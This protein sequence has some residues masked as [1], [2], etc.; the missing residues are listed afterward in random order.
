MFTILSLIKLSNCLYWAT[1]TEVLRFPRSPHVRIVCGEYDRDRTVISKQV[2]YADESFYCIFS[3]LNR[4]VKKHPEWQ[5]FSGIIAVN[6]VP[7]FVYLS[8]AINGDLLLVAVYSNI[9]GPW[10]WRWSII[11][12]RLPGRT[13][14]DIK[15]YWICHLSRKLINSEDQ[16][17]EKQ[18]TTKAEVIRPEPRYCNAAT[19]VPPPPCLKEMPHLQPSQEESSS[20]STPVILQHPEL[21]Q[22]RSE[23]GNR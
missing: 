3:D 2:A 9:Q 4:N 6:N 1:F 23:C 17:R 5:E 18:I 12:A 16:N 11:A 22:S 21:E 13:G 15:N 20:S 7:N 8:V 10:P 14:N 19:P